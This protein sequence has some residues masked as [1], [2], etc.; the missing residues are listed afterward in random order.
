LDLQ[1]CSLPDLFSFPDI[2]AQNVQEKKGKESAHKDI[3]LIN[4]HR[5]LLYII[6]MTLMHRRRR[7]GRRRENKDWF[8]RF[9]SP[10]GCLW[11]GAS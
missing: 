2:L 11:F 8:F 7:R 1:C 9:S 3:V 6:I 10:V 5:H 4:H